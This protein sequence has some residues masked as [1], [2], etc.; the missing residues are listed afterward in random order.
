VFLG[1]VDL[2]IS[3]Y[4]TMQ[5]HLT[6]RLCGQSK[7]LSLCSFIGFCSLMYLIGHFPFK[8]IRILIKLKVILF[9]LIPFSSALQEVCIHFLMIEGVKEEDEQRVA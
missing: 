6:I 4:D 8:I 5:N 7:D 1:A 2:V 3:L 9:S